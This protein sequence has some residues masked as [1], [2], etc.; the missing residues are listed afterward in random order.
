MN[1]EITSKDIFTSDPDKKYQTPKNG[2]TS[3][4]ICKDYIQDKSK[5]GEGYCTR[6][7]ELVF[8]ENCKVYGK[9]GCN[10]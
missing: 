5:K 10:K 4:N 3:E 8:E 2:L 7:H 1:L 9:G 6:S